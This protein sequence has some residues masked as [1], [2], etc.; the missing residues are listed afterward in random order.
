M[1]GDEMPEPTVEQVDVFEP[2]LNRVL[3]QKLEAANRTEGGIHLPYNRERKFEKCAVIAV[4][5][6]IRDEQGN[7]KPLSVQPGDIV[8]CGRFQ[9]DEIEVNGMTLALVHENDILGRV[10]KVAAVEA[11]HRFLSS[12]DGKKC[13]KCQKAK[14][15]KL[16]AVV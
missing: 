4:G 8:Y 9:M 10:K 12:R 7:Y 3:V 13:V 5:P 6:G 1:S 15:A 14:H 16:H 11:P 2:L